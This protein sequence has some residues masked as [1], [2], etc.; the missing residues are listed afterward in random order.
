LISVVDISDRKT[1]ENAL[2][3]SETM[4]R[5]VI[6]ATQDAMISIDEAG[7]ITLFNP[8]AEKMFGRGREEVIGQ[9]LDILMPEEYR[10]GHSDY[11]RSFFASGKPNAAI[12]KIVELP[13]IRADGEIFPIEISLSAGDSE[14]KRFVI[15]VLRDIT[16]R[17]RAQE[18]L[19]ESEQRF[20]DL[21]EHAGVG[22][23]VTDLNGRFTFA[24][25]TSAK[26]LGYSLKEFE[27]MGLDA[28]VHPDDLEWV[29]DNHRRRC[30]GEKIPTRY[31]L[32]AVKK[33]GSPV[34]L[35]ISVGVLHEDGRMI[36]SRTYLL[37]ITELKQIEEAL[38]RSDER[39]QSFS[40]TV[41]DVIY[42]YDVQ[43]DRFDFISPSC[44]TQTGYSPTEFEASPAEVLRRI[45]H[46]DDL[47]RVT[48]QF[49]AHLAKGPDA[50]TWHIEYRV[51]RKDGCVI[52]VSEFRDLEFAEDGE[53][54]CINGVVRDITIQ[55]LREQERLQLESQMQQAQKMESLGVLAGG[56]AHEFNNMLGGILGTAELMLSDLPTDSQL[57]KDIEQIMA[58]AGRAA[59]LTEQMLAYSGK[60]AFV[61]KPLDLSRV[62]REMSELLRTAT[63][64]GV[65]INFDLA[66]ELP[67]TVAD[68]SQIRQIVINLVSNAAE[69][70]TAEGGTIHCSTGVLEA[71]SEYMK[72]TV[73]GAEIPAGSYVYFEVSDEGSGMEATTIARMFEPFF[74][75]KFAGRGLGLAAVDGIVRGHNGTI[76]IESSPDQGTSIRVLLPV[77]TATE[78]IE[79]GDQADDSEYQ[80]GSI[81]VADAEETTCYLARRILQRAGYRVIQAADLEEASLLLATDELQIQLAMFDTFLPHG[82]KGNLHS[83]LEALPHTLPI[84]LSSS[85]PADED[86]VEK[87]GTRFQGFVRKPYRPQELL[88]TVQRLLSRRHEAQLDYT[89]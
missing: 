14:G 15:A 66:A 28:V 20:R 24:N 36:G 86:E 83:Q 51:I 54:L 89:L 38:R 73:A 59:H 85:D 87:S 42:R 31:E 62:V 61:V 74:T 29:Q 22:I 69:A 19:A 82:S 72:E 68:L 67:P 65:Q 2:R 26:L 55:K 63:P 41:T 30:L 1:A 25:E 60:G 18:V 10:Q 7:L 3:G 6:N 35:D 23:V 4:L 13:A 8:A 44:A 11:V 17:R 71:D 75:T 33:D 9:S 45:T 40:E 12:G 21:V 39:F 52:W 16:E 53:L 32:R 56:I 49:E 34:Y 88:E 80:R 46:P 78:R 43:R 27:E 48:R 77:A 79:G 81:L 37:D 57:R 5:T 76:R 84:I 70:M 50:G 58:A 47:D 64:K